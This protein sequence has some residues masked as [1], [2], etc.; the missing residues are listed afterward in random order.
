MRYGHCQIKPDGYKWECWV[1][2]RFG[3]CCWGFDTFQKA[4]EYARTQYGH[5]VRKTHERRHPGDEHAQNEF[6]GSISGPGGE[7]RWDVIRELVTR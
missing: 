3:S 4:L 2:G 6:W 1:R 7:M 5:E